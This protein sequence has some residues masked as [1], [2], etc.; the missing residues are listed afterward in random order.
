MSIIRSAADVALS[1]DHR[2]DQEYREALAIVGDQSRRVGRLVDDMLVLARADAG[3]YPLQV[4]DLDLSE[5]VADCRRAL[6]TLASQRSVQIRSSAGFAVPFRGDEDLLRRLVQN[7]MHNAIQ[8]TRP[9]GTVAVAAASESG[10]AT[11]RVS[12]EGSGIPEDDR[13]RIFDRFV[14]LD[15]VRGGNGTGL[16][17]PIARWIAEAHGGS[18]ILEA[19]GRGGSTFRATLHTA[20]DSASLDHDRQTELVEPR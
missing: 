3:G 5:V 12:D 9:G 15:E 2:S 6:T 10:G 13:S 18:L 7:L 14:R 8:H 17:L 1:R 20:A 16:G 4:V 11:I 19:S